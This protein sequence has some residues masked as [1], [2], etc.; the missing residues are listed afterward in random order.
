MKRNTFGKKENKSFFV[1]GG[2]TK[3]KR[4]RGKKE[5][6]EMYTE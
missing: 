4:N 6:K 1:R 5:K 2:T 3:E